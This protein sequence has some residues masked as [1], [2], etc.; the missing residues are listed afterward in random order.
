MP[1]DML[2]AVTIY[3]VTPLDNG[4]FVWFV[5]KIPPHMLD[6]RMLQTQARV[7]G[8]AAEPPSRRGTAAQ[9]QA[10]GDPALPSQQ[11]Q[12]LQS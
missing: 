9:V 3:S 12:P 7:H 10:A 4:F 2:G 8:A 6:S 5:L 11:E 1:D